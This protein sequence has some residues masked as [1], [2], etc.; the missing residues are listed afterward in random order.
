MRAGSSFAARLR[1]V[2]RAA[3]LLRLDERG[4]SLVE[5][6]VALAIMSTGIVL[7][8]AGLTTAGHG[9]TLFADRVASQSL[10]RSQLELI[11]DH[12]Y[13]A[14]PTTSPYPSASPPAPYSVSTTVDYWD[15]GTETFVSGVRNDGMQRITVTVSK[16]S[17]S[18][19]S[20]S[21]YKVDR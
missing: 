6:L 2:T 12:P 1:P 16:A 20:V 4:F 9:I 10:A 13:I 14:D 21:D 11:K 15:S 19:L 18:V 5:Q 3:Q 8:L 7:L 17:V